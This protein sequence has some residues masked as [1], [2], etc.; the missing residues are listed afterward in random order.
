MKIGD[1]VRFTLEGIDYIRPSKPDRLGTVVGFS[2]KTGSPRIHW[3]GTSRYTTH[4]Y[5]PDFVQVA[6]EASNGA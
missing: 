2:R 4:T 3:D 1:R 5:H 6:G